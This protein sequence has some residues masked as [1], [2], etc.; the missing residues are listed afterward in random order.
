MLLAV[1]LLLLLQM[2]LAVDLLLLLQML[3]A[4]DLLL[5]LQMLLAVD[6]LLLQVLEV[7]QAGSKLSHHLRQTHM[8]RV[9]DHILWSLSTSFLANL[10]FLI[11]NF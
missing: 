1:D 8:F 3:L 5:L 9:I 4:V 11:F 2:L 7:P 6:L 10:H